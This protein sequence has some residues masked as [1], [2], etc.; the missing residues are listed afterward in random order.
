MHCTEGGVML[1]RG[2]LAFGYLQILLRYTPDNR[3]SRIDHFFSLFP[4]CMRV[5]RLLLIGPGGTFYYLTVPTPPEQ[6]R[7]S[8]NTRSKKS[9]VRSITS[10]RI[11]PTAPHQR[12]CYRRLIK[13]R[14]VG[15]PS[16]P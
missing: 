16:F 3:F 1:G 12:G 8:G 5:L 6:P 2:L 7:F 11:N 10:Y 13:Q 4:P 14:C 9:E 15:T